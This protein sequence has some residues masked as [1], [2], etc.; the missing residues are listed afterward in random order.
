[1]FGHDWMT[2]LGHFNVFNENFTHTFICT[3]KMPMFGQVLPISW[4]SHQ[5]FCPQNLTENCFFD[6]SLHWTISCSHRFQS[7][8]KGLITLTISRIYFSG[9]VQNCLEVTWTHGQVEFWGREGYG[10]SGDEGDSWIYARCIRRKGEIRA[11]RMKEE[12][13]SDIKGEECRASV[14]VQDSLTLSD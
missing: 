10:Q 14:R 6:L 4:F 8:F 11:C 7:T 9:T 3:S 2:V 5:S 1:M 12:I 13:E